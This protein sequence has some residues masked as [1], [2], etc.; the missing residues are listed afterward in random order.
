L[1]VHECSRTG[2][3][4]LQ[5]VK[6]VKCDAFGIL[7]VFLPSMGS[8]KVTSTWRLN[9]C[10]SA[11]SS[12]AVMPPCTECSPGPALLG[13]KSGTGAMA[14]VCGM[15]AENYHSVFLS[16]CCFRVVE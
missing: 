8:D 15:M 13:Q 16:L 5:R 11:H 9:L 1:E 2:F 12:A 7:S 14:A 10:P 3:I 6:K 4:P